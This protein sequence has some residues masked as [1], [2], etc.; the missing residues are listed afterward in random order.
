M[1]R[2]DE[3][4]SDVSSVVVEPGDSVLQGHREMLRGLR[5]V[6]QRL[7][8]QAEGILDGIVPCTLVPVEKGR[9]EEEV[10]RV[11]INPLGE[12]ESVCDLAVKLSGAMA[13]LIALEREAHSLDERID[14]KELSDDQLI[15]ILE[16]NAPARATSTG[17]EPGL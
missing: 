15:R 1:P 2:G 13:K 9:G 8:I 4:K 14:P 11:R 7:T 17:V 10:K 12:R 16:R 3:L 6:V 5:N